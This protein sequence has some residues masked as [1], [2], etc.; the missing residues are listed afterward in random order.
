LILGTSLAALTY[1]QF[2]LPSRLGRHG[3]LL[4]DADPKGIDIA[5]LKYKNQSDKALPYSPGYSFATLHHLIKQH[6]PVGMMLGTYH[7][8]CWMMEKMK[9]IRKKILKDEI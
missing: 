5:S 3:I 9:D 7:N 2:S 8:I 6:E 1:V 4:S